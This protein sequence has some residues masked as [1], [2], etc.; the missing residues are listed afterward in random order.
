MDGTNSTGESTQ[1]RIGFADNPLEGSVR[2][3]HGGG[4]EITEITEKLPEITEVTEVTEELPEITE[5]TEITE[6]LPEITEI[7]EATEITEKLPEI[8]DIPGG[9][10]C[11]AK[12]R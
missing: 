11:C 1:L 8:T 7:T 5:A 12:K 4:T 9:S 2:H 6:E 3:R 10:P